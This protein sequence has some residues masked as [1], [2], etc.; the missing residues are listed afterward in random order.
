MRRRVDIAPGGPPPAAGTVV[1]VLAQ[2]GGGT[3]Y[4]LLAETR[5]AATAEPAETTLED[6]YL[7]LAQQHEP[8]E[9]PADRS[10]PAGQPAAGGLAG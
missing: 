10:S 9:A 7:A 5:P 4:R 1:A 2:P 6:G 3:R 8:A